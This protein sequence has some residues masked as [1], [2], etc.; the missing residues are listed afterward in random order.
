[1]PQQC[2]D[3]SLLSL[4][5]HFNQTHPLIFQVIQDPIVF[6]PFLITSNS[7]ATHH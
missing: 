3:L 7:T 6:N 2:Q 4:L 1:M 5:N